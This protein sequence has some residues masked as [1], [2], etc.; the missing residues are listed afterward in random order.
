MLNYLVFNEPGGKFGLGFD[1]NSS[2]VQAF[3]YIK[4]KNLQGNYF[5]SP[6]LGGAM[7]LFLY[8]Q[9]RVFIDGRY[10]DLYSDGFY[11]NEYFHVAS[12]FPD[13][14]N[15]LNIYQVDY[16]LFDPFLYPK[17]A[18]VISGNPRWKL[19]YHDENTLIY[20]RN[21]PENRK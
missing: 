12:G 8:T 18:L 5:N 1:E 4:E 13:W 3:Q 2:P 17:L 6:P 14:E 21:I 15:K 16:V 9:V 19:I 20:G 11:R 10:L 7:I